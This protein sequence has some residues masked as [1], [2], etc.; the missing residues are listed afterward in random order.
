MV[1]G[2]R[3]CVVYFRS[4]DDKHIPKVVACFKKTKGEKYFI[5]PYSI[6]SIL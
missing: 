6:A 1:L 4:E 2:I 5:I 3:L